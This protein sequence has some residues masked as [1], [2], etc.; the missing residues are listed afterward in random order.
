MKRVLALAVLLA[1]AVGFVPPVAEAANGSVVEI[2]AC[3][4]ADG[5]YT[6]TI[7]FDNGGS[8]YRRHYHLDATM[9]GGGVYQ[10]QPQD[11]Y[12][13]ETFVHTGWPAGTQVMAEM[14]A[15]PPPAEP[16]LITKMAVLGPHYP[17]CGSG[18][19]SHSGSSGR[20]KPLFNMWLFTGGGKHCILVSDT[21]PSVASQQALCFPGQD[22]TAEELLC[23]GALYD[24]DSWECDVYGK[25]R[26]HVP[27]LMRYYERHKIR[28]EE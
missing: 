20:A 16:T 26:L 9:V 21:H 6:V 15:T 1:L 25:D 7:H 22:W 3:Q 18:C 27:D 10:V 17:C 24:D 14:D 8:L 2:S 13:P 23:S 12:G 5:T 28:W 19:P 11:V 4:E